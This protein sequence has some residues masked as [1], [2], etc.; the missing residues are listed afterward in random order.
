MPKID[1][2]KVADILRKNELDPEILNK[3]LEDINTETGADDEQEEKPP[4][5]KKQFVMLIS[6]PDHELPEKDF[7]G[8]VAQIP[9]S[10]SPATV[11]ERIH[12]A[13][14]DFNAS[15]RGR[16]MPILSIGEAC[17]SVAAKFFKEHQVAIKTKV[18]VLIVKT[19]NEIPTE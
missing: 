3:I 7:V 1:I 10:D 6:D 17:E 5:V 12:K 9:E 8:W 2:E 16:K 11:E 19:N 18:P 13:V 15:P 14:Y 4:P